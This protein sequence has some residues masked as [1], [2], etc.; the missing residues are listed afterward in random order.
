MPALILAVMA[1]TLLIAPGSPQD[2]VN[3]PRKE[4]VQKSAKKVKELQKERLAVLR[5]LR[6]QLARLYQ[7]ARV[8][9]DELL[10]ARVQLFQAELDAAE[11]QSDRLTLYKNLVEELKQYEKIAHAKV[12]AGQ[13]LKTSVLKIKARRLEA[14][15]HLEQA[16]VAKADVKHQKIVVSSPQVKNVTITQQYVCQIY[17]HRHIRVRSL[18]TGYLEEVPVKEGQAVK[19]DDLLFKVVPTLY[20]AKLDAELAE[21]KLAELGL[22]NA[23]KLVKQNIVSPNEVALYRAKLARAQAKAKLAEA[24]YKFT[25]VRAPFDGIID[26]LHEQQGSL[27]NERDLLTTLSD[28]SVMWVYFNVPEARYL[29]YKLSSDQEHKDQRIELVLANGSK[30]P[31]AS[32]GLTVEGQFNNENGN[33]PFRADFPNP[34]PRLL[35]HGM[36]GTILVHRPLKN[37]IV[38]PQRATFEILDKRYVYVVDKDG[39]AH[40]REIIVRHELDDFFVIYRGRVGVEDRIVVEGIQQV[41][42]GEKVEYEFRPPGQVPGHQ[43][44][45]PE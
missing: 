5:A 8:G 23:E 44:N 38:I 3:L 36:T 15:I 9:I 2:K 43:K 1:A 16:K 17:A 26:R 10:E 39:V 40:Q 32:T 7:N 34:E 45:H 4:Q 29:E 33:I 35:R 19:K 11:K 28:N 21:T 27:V 37:A 6:D 20:K 41:R 24:E 30:F 12:E 31:H 42:D 25:E 14:E 22:K 13:G 18:Q